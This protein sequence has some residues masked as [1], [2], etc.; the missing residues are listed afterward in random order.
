ME[1]LP[2]ILERKLRE[3]DEKYAEEAQKAGEELL[4]VTENIENDTKE[5]LDPIKEQSV[6]ESAIRQREGE[7]GAQIAQIRNKINSIG[8][9]EGA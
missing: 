2:T 6:L 9:T 5:L 4:S 3:I 8:L 7:D 1:K